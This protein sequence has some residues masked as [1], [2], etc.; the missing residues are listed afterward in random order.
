MP[1]IAELVGASRPTVNLWRG[2]YLEHGL[3]GLVDVQRPG[4]PKVV[5][6]AAII[7]ATLRPP[8]KSL[9]VTHW[10]SRLLAPRL[11]VHHST[12]TKAWKKYG[13]RP[14]KADTFKFSTDPELEAKV[15]DA[16]GLYL[17]SCTTVPDFRGFAR[18]IGLSVAGRLGGVGH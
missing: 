9:G 4:R 2:R 17:L 11:G 10:S 1:L 7:T 18:R 8:P 14:W 6:D 16:V 3:E 12:V 13:V 15:I 5:D